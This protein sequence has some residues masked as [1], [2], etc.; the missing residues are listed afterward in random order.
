MEEMVKALGADA[1]R[2]ALRP[3][4]TGLS[5]KL[6][7]GAENNWPSYVSTGHY[8]VA[9][10]YT[11]TEH[12]MGPEV[13]IMSRRAWDE[14]SAED[15]TIFRDAAQRIDALHARAMAELGGAV[16]Q[17]GPES[18]VTVVDTIDRKPFEDATAPLRDAMRADPSFG[19]LIGRIEAGDEHRELELQPQAA[20]DRRPRRDAAASSLQQRAPASDPLA[21]PV[22]RRA[23][24]RRGRSSSRW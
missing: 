4:R 8:R 12:T 16:A 15:R 2:P 23:Q 19:P 3:G 21:H 1:G 24:R 14:L 20:P 22:H 6:I 18:G 9:P 10:F 13:V 5:A 7:D 11:L 17:A